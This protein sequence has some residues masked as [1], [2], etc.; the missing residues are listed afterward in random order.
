MPSTRRD[1]LI[2]GGALTVAVATFSDGG[3]PARRTGQPSAER[4]RSTFQPSPK[5]SGSPTTTSKRRSRNSMTRSTPSRRVSRIRSS[6]YMTTG[7]SAGART[8]PGASVRSR[9]RIRRTKI[10]TKRFR[11]STVRSNAFER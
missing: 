2:A 3:S 8:A 7:P 1:L 4:P 5:R 6:R 9:R 10:A 11:R